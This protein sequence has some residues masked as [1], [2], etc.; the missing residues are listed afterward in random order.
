MRPQSLGAAAA[1]GYERRDA[2]AKI[3]LSVALAF[4]LTVLGVE[5]GLYAAWPRLS[6]NRPWT[7]L[8]PNLDAVLARFPPPRL[9]V[10]P[11]RELARVLANERRILDSY[12]WVDREHGVARVPIERAMQLRVEQ[13]AQHEVPPP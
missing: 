3:V 1:G 7:P 2:R 11:G 10:T 8:P 12:G 13:R 5:A 9:H 6:G 4:A